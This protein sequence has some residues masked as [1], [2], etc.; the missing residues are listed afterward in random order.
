M[1]Y[2]PQEAASN[3]DNGIPS[4]LV[5]EINIWALLSNFNN[6]FCLTAL[7]IGINNNEMKNLIL[8]LIKTLIYDIGLLFSIG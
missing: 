3:I 5:K 2:N 8:G 4:E 6:S 7:K 1:G